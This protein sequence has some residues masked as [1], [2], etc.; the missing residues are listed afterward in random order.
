MF[1]TNC[2]KQLNDDARFCP[3]CAHPTKNAEPSNEASSSA[4]IPTPVSAG[5]SPTAETNPASAVVSSS[6]PTAT[7]PVNPPK[8]EGTPTGSTL[9]ILGL[10]IGILSCVILFVR[11]TS[12]SS[13]Y[14]RARALP[15]ESPEEGS[16]CLARTCHCGPV[17]L[18]FCPL[19]CAC[20]FRLRLNDDRHRQFPTPP[21]YAGIGC[22]LATNG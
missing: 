3:H 16:R 2:G 7:H 15:R 17:L 9:G 22:R 20:L 11:G 21:R 18:R 12:C 13:R 14:Y 1:C 6:A 4:T 5:A 10:V 19:Q 8:E